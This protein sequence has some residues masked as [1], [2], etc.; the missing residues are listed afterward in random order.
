MT[1]LTEDVGGM[2]RSWTINSALS[3]LRSFVDGPAV[4]G[5]EP[6]VVQRFVVSTEAG[7]HTS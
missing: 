6:E 7:R 3:H 5:V 4:R 1:V 2:M